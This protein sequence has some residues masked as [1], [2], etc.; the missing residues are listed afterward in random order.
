MIPAKFVPLLFSR[1]LENSGDAQ[2]VGHGEEEQRGGLVL[3]ELAE[4]EQL[5]DFDR[6]RRRGDPVGVFE[7]LDRRDVVGGGAHPAD[8]RHDDGHLFGRRPLDEVAKA[9][10]LRGLEARRDNLPTI[11][12]NRD[13]GVA[14]DPAEGKGE[15]RH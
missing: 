1:G 13:T 9:A 10:Q 11:N 14:F 2:P 7:R 3:D 8:A 6:Q 15:R 4:Q 12:L 5:A